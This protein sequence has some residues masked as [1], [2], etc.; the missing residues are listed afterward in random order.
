M[1]PGARKGG[2]NIGFEDYNGAPRS[3]PGCELV[4]R[5]PLEVILRKNLVSIDSIGG[6]TFTG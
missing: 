4:G 2:G 1:F 5:A 3:V 6:R